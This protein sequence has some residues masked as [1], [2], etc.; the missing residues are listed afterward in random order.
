MGIRFDADFNKEIRRVVKNFNAK[1][2]RL[3]KKGY[4]NLPPRL[5]AK[6]LKAR[7]ATKREIRADLARLEKFSRQPVQEVELSGGGKAIK[8]EL[9]YIKKQQEYAKI[10]WDKRIK[11]LSKREKRFPAER[12]LLDNAIANRQALDFNNAYL[13]QEQFMDKR[14][15]VIQALKAPHWTQ[16]NYRG[17]LNE[18]EGVMR[19]LGYDAKTINTALNKFSALTPDQFLHV[20]N[21][22]DIIGKVYA[23]ADSPEDGKLKLNT[24]EAK[25][26]E[27][28]EGF[29]SQVDE[30]VELGKAYEG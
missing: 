11:D 8:W 14:A 19:V 12:S 15:S 29:L 13:T 21:S 10:Y 18:V 20:Y 4:K 1:Q 7:Y 22:S 5:T 23:L 16:R 9:D 24:S 27:D 2:T 17:F 3:T 26:E 6:E 30:L 28:I 25:A